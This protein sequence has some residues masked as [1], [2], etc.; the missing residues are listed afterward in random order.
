ME[1]EEEGIEIMEEEEEEIEIIEAEEERNE[2]SEAP[3]LPSFG[4]EKLME[5]EWETEEAQIK[6][7]EE[8][9]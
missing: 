1:A 4:E 6:E 8:F 7:V 9:N 2:T 3:P 5:E